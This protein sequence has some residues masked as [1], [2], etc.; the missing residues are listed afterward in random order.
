M[1]RREDGHKLGLDEA[2][3]LRVEGPLLGGGER[4]RSTIVLGKPGVK[5]GAEGRGLGGNAGDEQLMEAPV[6]AAGAGEVG[7]DLRGGK[8][9]EASMGFGHAGLL[10][11]RTIKYG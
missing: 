9:T 11:H 7:A 5:E 8:K 6:P 4:G 3:F 1:Q 10:G 2:R